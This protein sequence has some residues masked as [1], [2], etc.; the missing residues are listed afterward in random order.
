M[1]WMDE[2]ECIITCLAICIVVGTTI[3]L[4]AG[5]SSSLLSL[6]LSP[7]FTQLGWVLILWTAEES[8]CH[9]LEL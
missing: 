7:R 2:Q 5:S 9:S 3:Y 1:E 8:P 6:L 4:W